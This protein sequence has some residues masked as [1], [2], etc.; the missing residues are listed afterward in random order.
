M[1]SPAVP[2]RLHEDIDRA[3]HIMAHVIA[4]KMGADL[5]HEQHDLLDRAAL[6]TWIRRT[7]SNDAY[8]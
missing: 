2:G 3:P 7:R 5:E 6:S 1:A 4:T 8:A